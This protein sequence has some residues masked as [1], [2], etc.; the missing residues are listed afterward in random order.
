[1][2]TQYELKK[3]EEVKKAALLHDSSRC[4]AADVI[5]RPQM[6]PHY[7]SDYYYYSVLSPV[8]YN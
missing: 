8:I 5:S 2:V 3:T 7:R 1:M 6:Q 4:K